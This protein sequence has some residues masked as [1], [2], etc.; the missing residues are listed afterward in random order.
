MSLGSRTNPTKTNL[1]VF[2]IYS[3]DETPASLLNKVVAA[4]GLIRANSLATRFDA[5]A[6]VLSRPELR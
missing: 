6:T 2:V 4:L 5:L 3:P 1:Y